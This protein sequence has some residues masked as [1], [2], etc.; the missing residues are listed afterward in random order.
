MWIVIQMSNFDADVS[1]VMFKADEYDKAKAYLHWL[2]E[3][4]YN[5]EIA[6][7]TGNLLESQCYH[8][9]EYAVVTWQASDW[10][11]NEDKTEFILAYTSEPDY[12]FAN[13]DWQR[14]V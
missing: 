7:G 2:W 4:Y 1:C 11:E 3:D 13:V 10:N 9:D 6:E 12:R 5:T 14:Y 8:E